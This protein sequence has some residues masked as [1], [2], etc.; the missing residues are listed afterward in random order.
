M[1]TYLNLIDDGDHRSSVIQNEAPASQQLGHAKPEWVKL[2]TGH[3]PIAGARRRQSASRVGRSGIASA[4][5]S[6]GI[7]Q[8]VPRSQW[9]GRGRASN[10]DTQGSLHKVEDERVR[11]GGYSPQCLSIE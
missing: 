3:G 7:W 6:G 1:L 11:L 10:G 2:S 9:E 4:T 8:A 5:T